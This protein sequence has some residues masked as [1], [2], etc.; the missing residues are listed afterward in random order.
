M[1]IKNG[2]ILREEYFI[3]YLSLVMNSMQCTLEEAKEVTFERLFKKNEKTLG[4]I[5]FQHFINAYNELKKC[6][7]M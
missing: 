5:S 3:S 4:T 1:I 2:G 7:D 6:E